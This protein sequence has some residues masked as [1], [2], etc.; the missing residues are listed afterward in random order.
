[1]HISIEDTKCKLVG[2]WRTSID[3][4]SGDV[5]KGSSRHWRW[6]VC[7]VFSPTPNLVW[8][9][10]VGHATYII[11]MSVTRSDDHLRTTGPGPH[12]TLDLT[13]F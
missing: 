2:V 4:L 5:G 1:M 8:S 13:H 11:L 12:T 9:N 10:L 3:T 7:C 6:Q